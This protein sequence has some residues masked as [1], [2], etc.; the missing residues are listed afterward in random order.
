[1]FK[2]LETK[3]KIDILFEASWEVCNKVGG[4]YTVLST[5][6]HTLQ[7]LYKDKVVFIG[8]DVWTGSV[9]SPDFLEDDT[10]LGFWKSRD[11]LPHGLKVRTGRWN[12]P[13]KPL[14][15]LVGFEP[16]YAV[17]DEF[18][19]E[20]WREFGVDSLHAYGDYDEAC[21]F[22]HAVGIVIESIVG[23]APSRRKNILA[24]F[25]EWT[26]GMG[27]LYV[28]SRLPQ[29]GTLFTTHA[30][31]IG[32]SIC[33]NGKPLYDYLAGYHGD[34]MSRELNMESKHSLEKAAAHNA[35]CF[36]TVSDVT[37]AE[38]E[39]LLEKRPD[40]VTPN[41][42]EKNFVPSPSKMKTLAKKARKRL[43]DIAEALTGRSF[44]DDTMIIATSGRCEYR[45]KGLDLFLD[46]LATMEYSMTPDDRDVL[47]FVLVPAW[48]RA[49]REDLRRCLSD[50]VTVPGGLAA[51]VITHEL[52][53][54][55]EDVILNRIR[56][57]GVSRMNES[58]VHVVYVPCYLD[59]KD[60]IVDMPYY[61]VLPGLDATVFASYYEPWGYT[62]LE[63]VAF[64]VPTVTTS[65]SGFGQWVSSSRPGEGL[66]ETGVEVVKR[67]DSNYSHV[68]SEIMG[69]LRRISEFDRSEKSVVSAA[70]MATADRAA[71]NYF[72]EYYVE[73]YGIAL[74]AASSRVSGT[75]SSKKKNK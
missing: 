6:A 55:G 35:D 1:M 30:T 56:S 67:T 49:A 62:P 74:K 2:D 21:A 22:S 32:R 50:G 26:T 10:V 33:G 15:V 4:I 39:Q 16:M 13:G 18:Y 36:T 58:K 47:A 65:L 37:A 34:Q 7:R 53:N 68:I 20:M 14:A 8:P 23:D 29:V 70:A 48:A 43:T 25:N 42:F 27:L 73:S 19:G 66:S 24:H 71:W 40:V 72:I 31:C 5:R 12:V 59:G 57:F 41:G 64:G 51:P 44:G 17:K 38:C 28:K 11:S 63:S 52:N 54:P 69:T 61:D 9:E 60:G 75:E 45:N 46:M 3:L